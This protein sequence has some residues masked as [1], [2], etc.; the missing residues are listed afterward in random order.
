MNNKILFYSFFVLIVSI[1]ITS[2]NN[3]AFICIKPRFKFLKCF[4]T[5]RRRVLPNKGPQC[6]VS[7]SCKFV[8]FPKG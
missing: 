8:G 3:V 7:Q 1:I 4:Q 2:L 5:I 6:N